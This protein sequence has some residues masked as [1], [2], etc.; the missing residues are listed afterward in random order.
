MQLFAGFEVRHG[1]ARHGHLV[2]GA[3]VAPEPRTTR[4][5]GEGAEAAQLN[6]SP[7]AR[8]APICSNTVPTIR[9]MSRA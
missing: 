2:A 8:A 5:G 6:P 9:S 1:L 3:R 7:R 4:A